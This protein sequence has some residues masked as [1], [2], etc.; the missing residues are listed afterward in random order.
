M[1]N[2]VALISKA[3][4]DGIQ[5][6]SSLKVDP[7]V[8]DA[9]AEMVG[10]RRLAKFAAERAQKV[11]SAQ[12]CNIRQL[13]QGDIFREMLLQV[14][15]C[16]LEFPFSWM[17]RWPQPCFTMVGEQHANAVDKKRLAL[18]QAGL[19]AERCVKTG[20]GAIYLPI[21]AYGFLQMRIRPQARFH[22]YSANQF[23]IDQHNREVAWRRVFG[24]AMYLAWLKQHERPS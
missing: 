12:A 23:W 2:E 14:I 8:L 15:P 17:S 3:G 24:I 13:I 5:R 11:I 6:N 10:M 7:D 9:Q 4:V 1:P 22:R 21:H 20:E 16:P 18:Q 19:R